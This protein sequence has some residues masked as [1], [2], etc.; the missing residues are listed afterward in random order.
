MGEQQSLGQCIIYGVGLY[1]IRGASEGGHLWLTNVQH[2][3]YSVVFLG[4]TID[5][6]VIG[7]N[8]KRNDL[9]ENL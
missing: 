4:I 7:N 5:R 2:V 3:R 8:F 1:V 9:A 6:T